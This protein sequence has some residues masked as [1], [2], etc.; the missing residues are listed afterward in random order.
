LDWQQQY[1]SDEHASFYAGKHDTTP[2]RRLSNHFERKM[3][4]RALQRVRRVAP[5]HTA[6]DCASGTGRFLPTLASYDVSVIAMDTSAPMLEQGRRY[7]H[8]FR[9][10]PELKVGSALDI[11]LPDQSVDL[12][13]CSRLLH[14]FAESEQRVLIFKEFA[15]VARSGV[16]VTFFDSFSYR[17][18]RRNRKKRRPEKQHGRYTITRAQCAH[19]GELAGLKILGMNALLRYHTEITAAAF[20]VGSHTDTTASRGASP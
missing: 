7:H 3:V 20:L 17:G 18:W 16:V 9:N 13:L 10:T 5:F 11:P 15:R 19:E 12:V 4:R 1:K 8:L 2:L 14:H 6:L